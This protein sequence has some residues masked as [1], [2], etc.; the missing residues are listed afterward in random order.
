MPRVGLVVSVFFN[1]WISLENSN[2]TDEMP[3]TVDCPKNQLIDGD[4]KPSTP[5]T[6]VPTGIPGLTGETGRRVSDY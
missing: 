2:P 3:T 1:V 5:S 6:P 4:P